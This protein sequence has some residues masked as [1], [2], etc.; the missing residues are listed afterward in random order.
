MG[1]E[2]VAVFSEIDKNALHTKFADFKIGISGI[3]A[4]DSYLD[5]DKIINSAKE[6]GADAIHP[7]YGFL[8]ENAE[9][10][11]KVRNSGLIYIGPNPKS[12]ALLGNKTSSR[13]LMIKNKVPVVPGFKSKTDNYTEYEQFANK[14]GYPVLIKAAS[15]GGGKGMRIVYNSNELSDAIETAKRES[16]SAFGSDEIFIEKYI[17]NPRHIEFQVAGD[18]FGNYIHLFERE[19]SLQRR[20]QKIIEE[21]PSLALNNELRQKMAESAI[22]AVSSAEYDS[23]GTVE[24]LLDEYNNY[25]FLEVNT[26]IQVEHPITEE[27][28]GVDLVK[29]QID[30]ANGLKMPINQEDIK[31]NGWAIECRI[32]A[33]DGYNNFLPSSGKILK[34]NIPHN[35][36]IRYDTGIE[37]GSDI[38]V[39]Y[40]PILAKL[41]VHSKTREEA[42][43]KMINALQE[44]IILGVKTSIKFMISI[45]KSDEFITAN[46]YTNLIDENYKKFLDYDEE[47][48]LIYALA[49]ASVINKSNYKRAFLDPWKSIAKWEILSNFNAETI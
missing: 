22:M 28:T 17:K 9:F 44:N 6:S 8:S 2:T 5:I 32:Y 11:R 36:G 18:K 19:C 1:I 24:F 7:G 46:T 21:T 37:Q 40:D 49:S 38:S 10:N 4:K 41:I 31:Q 15:G 33:E 13:E 25:Y 47:N 48:N 42:R 3:S 16:L 43:L 30:I 14:I 34:L 12:M 23:V 20:H 45:L 39:F 27:V 26:R 29:L 35:D